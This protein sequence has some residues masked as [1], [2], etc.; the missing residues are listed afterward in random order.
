VHGSE[1]GFDRLPAVL[2]E[3]WPPPSRMSVRRGP[4][5]GR[6]TRQYRILLSGGHPVYLLPRTRKA[7]V[8]LRPSFRGRGRGK[9]RLIAGLQ[10]TG[11]LQMAPL[12]LLVVSTPEGA[13]SIVTVVRSVFPE[14]HDLAIRFGR[15]RFDRTTVLWLLD[16]AGAPLGVVKTSSTETSHASLERE[17]AAIVRRSVREVAGLEV[18]EPLAYFQWR[19]L[20]LLVL[21]ALVS[22]ERQAQ[23]TAPVAQM[24]AFA[25]ANGGLRETPLSRTA[26]ARRLV[27]DISELR[28]PD[29]QQW[30]RTAFQ[31]LLADCGH[32]V[33]EEGQWHGDWVPWNMTWRAGHVLLWDWE[34]YSAA[35]LAGFDHL[36][37]DA[38]DIRNQVGTSPAAQRRWVER[39]TAA[40]GGP[41]QQDPDQQRATLRAYLIEINVRYVRDRDQ[42]LEP[43]VPR[44][45]WGQPLI[46]ELAGGIDT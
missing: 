34:H 26:W 21:D 32:V 27:V 10:R 8:A 18:P 35:A 3:L 36:H 37:F 15:Q 31:Q 13:D 43:M 44:R 20:N 12:P 25:G 5:A 17:F 46:D 29:E 39:A 9:M 23:T 2:H 45:G 28:R 42:G 7:A 14:V 4:M 40:L 16:R 33:V 30:L 11:L 38:Q 1:P 6:L 19:T 24:L 22:D 41:W